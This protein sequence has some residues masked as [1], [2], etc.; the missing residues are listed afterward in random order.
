LK[1]N[2]ARQI[3]LKKYNRK[4]KITFFSEKSRKKIKH[5]SIA[6]KNIWQPDPLSIDFLYLRQPLYKNTI[7][8]F[9]TKI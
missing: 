8:T 3:S 4:H 1:K 6:E 9:G 2:D 7:I 5:I